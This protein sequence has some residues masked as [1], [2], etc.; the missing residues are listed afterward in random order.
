MGDLWGQDVNE[1]IVH[2]RNVAPAFFD[3]RTGL[4]GETLQKCSNYGLRLAL[5][6]DF[7]RYPS[8]SLQ[9]FIRESNR[10]RVVCFVNTVDEALDALS[11]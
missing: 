3:L 4:A 11:G 1:L 8:A 7:G 10:G 2:E 5:V 9:A 6:G